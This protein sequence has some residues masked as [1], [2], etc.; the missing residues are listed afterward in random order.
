MAN[1]ILKIEVVET[2][3]VK[4]M[5]TGKDVIRVHAKVKDT[6]RYPSGR[7]EE[8]LLPVNMKSEI[9][10]TAGTHFVECRQTSMEGE[11]YNT[12]VALFDPAP[13]KK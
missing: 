1:V 6:K 10:V 13:A 8:F 5:K 11:I 4:D 3:I 9:Q 2:A 7:T 12:I